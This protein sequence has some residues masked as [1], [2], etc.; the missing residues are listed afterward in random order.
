MYEFSPSVHINDEVMKN[1]KK[2]SVCI[3]CEFNM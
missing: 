3:G 1:G 2:S